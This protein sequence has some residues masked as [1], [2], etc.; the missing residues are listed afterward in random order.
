[1]NDIVTIYTDGACI[2]NPG[3]GGWGAVLKY[4]DIEKH[5]YGGDVN[6][7]NNRME[8]LAAVKSLE[9]LKRPCTVKV[10]SDS[11]Y[12]VNGMSSWIHG[13]KEKGWKNIK[14]PDLWQKLDSVQSTHDVEWI[15]VKGHNGDH[16]NEIADRL[17]NTGAKSA[18]K[19]DK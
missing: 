11:Q 1:M 5:I 7:T 9:T 6:T 13:W 14:N 2:G 4:K 18:K 8:L 17:A 15:W 16:Y 12:L 3:P 19:F 10:Y